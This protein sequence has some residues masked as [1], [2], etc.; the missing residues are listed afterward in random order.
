MEKVFRILNWTDEQKVLFATYMLEREA[1]HWWRMA[2]RILLEQGVE[3]ISWVSFLGVFDEK[4]FPIL[5]CHQ[6]EAKFLDL[7][8]A[9]RTVAAYKAKFTVLSR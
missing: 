8:Q 6:K 1:F 2:E 4:Y 9:R 3:P 7:V 5:V